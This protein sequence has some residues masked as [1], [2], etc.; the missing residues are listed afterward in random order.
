MRSWLLASLLLAFIIVVIAVAVTVAV[1][2][3]VPF[4]IILGSLR[5]FEEENDDEISKR[6]ERETKTRSLFLAAKG[7]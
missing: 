3:A 2:F 6:R 5:N 1:V 4:I 7:N